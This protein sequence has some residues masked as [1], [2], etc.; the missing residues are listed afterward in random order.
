MLRSIYSS[1]SYLGF[2]LINPEQVSWSMDVDDPETLSI[3]VLSDIFAEAQ[4]RF[5]SIVDDITLVRNRAYTLIT[6][7]ITLL[8]LLSSLYFSDTTMANGSR[9]LSLLFL[10]N[11]VVITY[12]IIQCVLILKPNN[13]MVKGEEPNLMN[14]TALSKL[15]ADDQERIYVLN[16]IE[17]LQG[18]ILYNE[19][20]LT[21]KNNRLER[22]LF[23][24]LFTF[25]FTLIFAI[26]LSL[27]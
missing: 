14:F 10:F 1:L 2:N 24:V 23:I 17:A 20:I 16:S 5:I 19:E 9:V 15:A 3:N 21:D 7:F 18:K 8:S 11:I 13:I 22:V 6:L 25:I 4:L 26:F 12:V 27:I